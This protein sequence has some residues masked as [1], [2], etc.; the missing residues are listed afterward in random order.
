MCGSTAPFL[1]GEM[2]YRRLLKT[3]SIVVAERGKSD[4]ESAANAVRLDRKTKKSKF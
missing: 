4:Y 3:Q 2:L 1:L